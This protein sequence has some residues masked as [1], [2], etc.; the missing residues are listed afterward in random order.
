MNNLEELRKK[1][2]NIDDEI[3]SLLNKRAE[4]VLKI[5]K[6]K[7]AQQLSSFYPEREREI[8][9]RLSKQNKGLFPQKALISVYNEIL[10]ACRALEAPLQIAYLGPEATFTHLAAKE[11]FGS[12]VEFIPVNSIS[13][14]F[15]EVEKR[16]ADFG[17]VPIESSTEGIVTHT[18]DMFIDSELNICSEI[19]IPVTHNLLSNSKLN[20]IKRV[21]YHPQSYAQSRTWLENNLHNV[22]YVEVYSTAEAARRASKEKYS[23]AIASELAANIYNLKIIKRRIEDRQEN[24]TRFLVIGFDT[25]P[26]TGN[27]KTSILFS[28]KDR[29]GALYD[30]LAPF[31]R[32]NINLTKIESRPTK[33][34]LWEYVFF[35]DLQGHQDDKEVKQALSELKELCI[36]LK[37]LGS[38]PVGE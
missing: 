28:I 5:G 12:S 31:A 37:I 22:E 3:L 36:Y 21:Y 29:V 7:K 18:L 16:R 35:L 17:V 20:E 1:I 4:I 15:T 27:D 38:Y 33:T 25:N 23:A 11:K 6:V 10:S 8:L 32:H 2:N 13:D 34:Q 14:V 9:N 26:P 24:I 19:L 30:M